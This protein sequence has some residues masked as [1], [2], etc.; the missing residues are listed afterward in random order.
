MISTDVLIIGSGVAGLSTAIYIAEKRK[1]LS[2]TVLT[3]RKKDNTN[4]SYAQGG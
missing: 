1:D 3:K 4:T 2:I